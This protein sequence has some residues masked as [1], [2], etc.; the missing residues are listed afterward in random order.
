MERPVAANGAT[1]HF[2]DDRYETMHA[3]AEQAPDLLA[4][5]GDAPWAGSCQPVAAAAWDCST[6]E[7]ESVAACERPAVRLTH[8]PPAP[9]AAAPARA[10][11]ASTWQTGA[12]TQR[13][14]GRRRRSCLACSS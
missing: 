2:V 12:T 14:S 13:R 5:C 6:A 1:L 9:A 10:G 7:E 4:R 3:I 11:G 8:V